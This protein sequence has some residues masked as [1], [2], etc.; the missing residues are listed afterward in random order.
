[1]TQLKHNELKC[2]LFSIIISL[3]KNLLFELSQF[4][5]KVYTVA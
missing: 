1:M 5:L 3:C 2:D 4:M